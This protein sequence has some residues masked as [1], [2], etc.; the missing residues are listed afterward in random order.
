MQLHRG[1][2]Q[3]GMLAA[4]VVLS[5]CYHAIIDTGRQP[6]GTVIEDKWADSFIGGLVPPDPI[7]T[8]QRCPAGIAKVETQHS[9][10]NLLVAAL[11]WSI[12]TPMQITV[13]CAAAAGDDAS[14]DSTVRVPAKASEAEVRAAFERAAQLSA[15]TGNAAW[16]VL[17]QE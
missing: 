10:L 16:L 5:G 2:I 15:A 12:Y 7:E 3:V 6:S 13:H 4:C 9:F 11:T 1:R 8:A 17:E 14:A